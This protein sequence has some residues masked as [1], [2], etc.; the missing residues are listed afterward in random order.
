M[1]SLDTFFTL[2][3][4]LNLNIPVSIGGHCFKARIAVNCSAIF[5]LLNLLSPSSE[6]ASSLVKQCSAA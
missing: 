1:F 2:P 4:K 5:A 3:L 6:K